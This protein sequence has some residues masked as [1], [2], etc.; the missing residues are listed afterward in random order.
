MRVLL[1]DSSRLW[2][3]LSIS[4]NEL[5]D[6]YN[7]S[8]DDLPCPTCGNPVAKTDRYCRNCGATLVET[9]SSLPTAP[10]PPQP[11]IE[12]PPPYQRKFSLLQRYY[13][14]LT[15]PSEAMSDIALA[16]DYTGYF[17]ILALEFALTIITLALAMQKIQFV[18]TYA[19]RLT[20]AITGILVLAVIIALVLIVVKWLIK[21]LI[22]RSASDSGSSWGFNTAASVTGYAYLA[23]AVIMI[24][25]VAVSWFLIPTFQ[26]DTTDLNVAIQ[27][28]ND[29]QAQVNLLRLTFSLP[30]NLLAVIWKS[31]LGGLGT[32][33]G[34]REKCSK[35]TGFAIF[36]VLSLVGLLISFV[37]S[38]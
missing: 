4:E 19:G 23:D 38:L 37:T 36:F 1:L 22:V 11:V 24:I 31:Y 17:G 9:S 28:M 16:P 29:Y 14:L 15:A 33:F 26:V 5:V 7:M 3:T 35:L 27:Q 25:G 30:F 8:A 20:S 6:V 12:A 2:Q 18:G 21:S 34:T 32:H 13:K 10:P